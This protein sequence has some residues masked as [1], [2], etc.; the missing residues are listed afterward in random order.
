MNVRAQILVPTLDDYVA[1]NEP[2]ALSTLFVF[3]PH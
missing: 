3:M 1:S 2:T